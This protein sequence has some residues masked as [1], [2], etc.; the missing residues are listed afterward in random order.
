MYATNPGKYRHR[1]TIQQRLT[2]RDP[3][4]GSEVLSDWLDFVA[5][6]PAEVL[7]G[8][9][10]ELMAANA[11][12]AEITARI[13]MRWFPGLTS[14]MRILWD[15]LVFAIAAPPETDSTARREWRVRCSDGLND[16]RG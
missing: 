4:D 15:G 12:Q 10:R 9:G 6:V 3:A 7:T 16:G 2:T 8:A 1:V 11:E 13:N 5:N 14:Q